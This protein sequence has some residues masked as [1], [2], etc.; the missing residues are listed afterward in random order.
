MTQ[1]LVP[2]AT[3]QEFPL[4]ECDN[5]DC[6]HRYLL[7]SWHE[8]DGKGSRCQAFADGECIEHPTHVLPQCQVYY[9]PYCGKK[10]QIR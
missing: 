1:R 5:P 10:N 3:Y 9:C 4:I 2:F 8:C 6:R 7:F